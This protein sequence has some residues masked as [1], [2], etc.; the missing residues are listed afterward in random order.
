MMIMA[1]Y[2]HILEQMKNQNSAISIVPWVMIICWDWQ[3]D[4]NERIGFTF[5]ILTIVFVFIC[6]NIKAYGK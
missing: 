6:G 4:S 1:A 2:P 5:Y 3:Y